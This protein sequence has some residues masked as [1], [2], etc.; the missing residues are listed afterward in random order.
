LA[1]SELK[2]CSKRIL[3]FTDNDAPDGENKDLIS[4]A[5]QK[6]KDLE[7]LDIAI[8]L[9]PMTHSGGKFE[10]RKFFKVL[11]PSAPLLCLVSSG[12]SLR[13]LLCVA[14]CGGGRRG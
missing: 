10:I 3:L 13:R 14:G 4:K 6:A 7:D 2:D 9:F 11:H 5:K 12:E 1:C 8:E